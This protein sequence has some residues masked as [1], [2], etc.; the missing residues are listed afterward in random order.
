MTPEQRKELARLLEKGEGISPEWARILFPPEKREYELVY[1]GKDR[2]EDIIADTL[3]V[4]LQPG[5]T[6]GLNGIDW[7]NMLIFGDNLQAMKTLLEMKR[8]GQ[9]RN[10][11]GSDGVRLVYIDPPFATKQDFRGTEDQKAYQDKIAGASFLEF[12]RKRLILIRELLSDNGALYV[13]LDWRKCHYIKTILD[14]V[15][16]EANFQNEIIWQRL[17]ARSDSHTYNHIHDVVYFYTKTGNLRFNVQYSEYSREYIKK[18]YR[19]YDPDGRVFS[20]GDLTARGLRNGESGRPWRGVDPARLGNHWKVKISTLDQLDKQGKIYWPPSGKVPRLKQYLDERH[21]RPLQSIW[22]DISPVQFASAENAN[23]PT[24]KPE[25]LLERVIK[26]S[27]DPGDLVLDAFAG[28]GTTLAVA[29]K[30]GRRWIGIDCGKLSIYTIQKRMLNLREKIGNKGAKLE[31][32]PFTLYN[33]GLYDFSTL[34]ELPWLNWRFFALQLFGCRDAPHKIGGILFDGYRQGQSVLV[35]NHMET[36]HK[37]AC[38]S[39]ETIE[40]IH[41][42]AG[43]RVGSKVFIVAPALAF[44]F[45]QDYIDLDRVRYYALRIPYSMIHE[46]H[47]QAF[48]ALK[49]PSDEMAVNDT[50]EAVGFD[51][52]RTPELKYKTGTEKAKGEFSEVGFIKIETFKSEAAV[53][54]PFKKKG[55]L[56]TLSMVMLDLDYNDAGKVFDLDAVYY[57]EALEKVGWKVRFQTDQLGKKMMAVFLDIYGNEARVLIDAAKFG[58]IKPKKKSRSKK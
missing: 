57:A 15:L 42:A 53:R 50:V 39:E 25:A 4:P 9:L 30:L 23:Y 18:F 46:L 34:K 35:F 29:E 45:Q 20:I 40:E 49:Q 10:A 7:H 52:I 24:Q 44:D 17:S 37:G 41:E 55:T 26:A 48:T 51:F 58:E 28:A 11:D 8:N 56:E 33:A 14:E 31:A 19:Y 2:E 1:H 16:G 32:K 36:K 47:R 3:A 38:I 22:S 43:S 12:L 13:H 54:E 6:F 27:S 5:R 21:G